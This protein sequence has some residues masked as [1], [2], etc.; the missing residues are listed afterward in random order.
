[1]DWPPCGLPCD[2]ALAPALAPPLAPALVCCAEAKPVPATSASAATPASKVFWYFFIRSLLWS[3]SPCMLCIPYRRGPRL[4]PAA[5]HV[6]MLTKRTQGR[7]ESFGS[8]AY[9]FG[10]DS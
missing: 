8:Q 3:V 10:I 9:L 6:G 2:P 1:M 5:A 7:R 4:N